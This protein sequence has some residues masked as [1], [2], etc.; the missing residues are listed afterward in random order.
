MSNVSEISVG[1]A[2]ELCITAVKAGFT[3]VELGNLAKNEEKM[4]QFRQVLLGHASVQVIEH[5][6]DCDADPFIPNGW[7]VEE[8]QKGGAF[9]W[10]T[11][12][13]SLFL[14]EPQK[15]GRSI[16]GNKLRNTLK[17]EPVLNANVLDYLLAHPDLIPEDWKG[18]YV[19]FWGT[20]YR[21]SGGGLFVRCLFWGGGRWGWNCDWLDRG[22]GGDDP[23][24][25]RAS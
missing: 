17:S 1:L 20:I 8:H 9:K 23:A 24:A 12:Q 22:F 14:S 21:S 5:L 19:F 25:L 7:K 11:S 10:N 3:S 2:H 13:V 18:K 16:E 15:R 6:I 4:R